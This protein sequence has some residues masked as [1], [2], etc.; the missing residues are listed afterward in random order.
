MG[1]EARARLGL[2]AVLLV[3]LYSF[4][5]LFAEAEYAGPAMLGAVIAML[6]AM[7]CRRLGLSIAVTVAASL[8]GM[9]WYL[10]LIF[11][12][13]RT[14][15]DL[16]TLAAGR[17]LL[18]SIG[19][20]YA[21]SQVDYAPVATQ[22]GYVVLVVLAFW[23]L[24]TIGEIATFRWQR[25]LI[26]SIGPIALFSL[27]MIVGT[28]AGA[29][30][31]V[32]AFLGALLTYWGLESAHRLRSWGRWVATWRGRKA[33]EPEAVTGGLA[34]R[35]GAACVAVTFL[36]PIFLPS[37]GDGLIAWRNAVGSGTFGTG[38]G[39][40]SSGQIDPLVSIVPEFFEQSDAEMLLVTADE[41]LY[42]RLVTLTQFD[43]QR[44]TPGSEPEAPATTGAIVADGLSVPQPGRLV[45]QEFQIVGLRGRQVPAASVPA[46]VEF[47]GDS[48]GEQQNL[49]FDV[50][51]G[52]L[53]LE[54]PL[55][56][57][58]TYTVLS[59]TPDASFQA[60]TEAQP[61]DLGGEF[62]AVPAH[63]P[64]IDDIAALWTR[65]ADS[66]YEELL[67]IQDELRRF[68][69]STAVDNSASSDYLHR[70][71]TE[72]KSGYCQ[73]FATAF[74]VLARIR[75]FSTRVAVGFLPGETSVAT[76]DEYVVRGTDA[77]AWPEVYFE[78]F[79]WVAFEPTPR[80]E[81]APP[82][83]TSPDIAGNV[84][85][86]LPPGGPGNQ[87][88]GP[89]GGRGGN[90]QDFRDPD[91][92]GGA[93][94]VIDVGNEDDTNQRWEHAFMNLTRALVV[95]I[96]LFLVAVPA[97]KMMRIRR[98]YLNAK[99]ARAR[100]AAAFMEFEQEA[101]ELAFPR[102]RSESA[103]SYARR[104]AGG[105]RVSRVTAVR[106]ARIFEAAQYAPIPIPAEQGD[107]A[108]VL[109]RELKRSL[110]GGATLWDRAMRLFSPL[111][112][113][114]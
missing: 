93:G 7:A 25:P 101:S 24:G 42:W 55:Q 75:G 46:T 89:G 79:G 67:A 106:L 37:L 39:G 77:H 14:F 86:G 81:A 19:R 36:A 63:D 32:P 27:V 6:L 103:V 54:R 95:M 29:H 62:T 100:A 5:Q 68:E 73:Q 47:T 71:L 60:M 28:N 59:T 74:A 45:S 114:S 44:W 50:N 43:G 40:A 87:G 107:E 1:S 23:V 30:L 12:A 13:D 58:L 3:V 97:L 64:E 99:D 51:T 56:E 22:P 4:S 94:G 70:F 31:L 76:P 98:R 85:F 92:G 16:P 104:V 66:R 35:M 108:R 82:G 90:L 112:L 48:E 34:R 38:P 105:R 11:Q 49:E 110:W 83:Y 111:G 91:Q 109:A 88:P 18:K 80:T 15:F 20:A 96:V 52:D 21:H 65:D 10:M 113:R 8:I 9:A 33:T 26:A 2:G 84:T 17:G 78:G 69:Y 72:T 102:E 53:E 41:P 57:G 61:G